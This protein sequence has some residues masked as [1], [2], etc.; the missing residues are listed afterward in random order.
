VAIGP[1]VRKMLDSSPALVCWLTDT[2]RGFFVDLGAVVETIPVDS[3]VHSFLN[4]GTGDGELV[5]VLVARHPHLRVTT[6]DISDQQGWLLK[7]EVRQ[8]VSVETRTP[9]DIAV[10]GFG[11]TFDI[12][13]MSDVMH[14]V[15]VE[16]RETVMQA[17]W[18]AVGPGGKLV[19]KD[20]ED[21]GV[22]AVLSLWSDKYLTGDRHTVLIN[23]ATLTN[24]IH[25]VRPS[26]S[27]E[28]TDLIHRNFPNYLVVATESGLSSGP[29]E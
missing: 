11:G 29:T 2:Y 21:R 13:F 28:T 9:E 12:V 19:I 22:K 16:D 25:N 24:L 20:I 18:Q 10:E 4:I 26:A 8:V 3:S 17:A 15:P 14:H 1:A 6:T 23:E 7:P 27:V 5:N